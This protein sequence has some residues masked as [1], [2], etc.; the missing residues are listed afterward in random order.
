MTLN[1]LR[2]RYFNCWK[3]AHNNGMNTDFLKCVTKGDVGRNAGRSQYRLAMAG[4][5]RVRHH[6]IARGVERKYQQYIQAGCIR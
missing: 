5:R 3:P 2:F 6:I 4:R 1:I